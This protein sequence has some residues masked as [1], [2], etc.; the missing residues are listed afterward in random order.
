MSRGP[1]RALNVSQPN[2][3][4]DGSICLLGSDGVVDLRLG[5]FLSVLDSRS[6]GRKK[7]LSWVSRC[8]Q[9]MPYSG[10]KNFWLPGVG[11]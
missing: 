3:R 1:R 6:F 8:R 7:L 4:E 2:S 9:K 10:D 5:G 11:I